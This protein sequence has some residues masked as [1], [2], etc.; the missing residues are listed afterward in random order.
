MIEES[1]VELYNRARTVRERAYVPYSE[2]AVGAALRTSDGR[3]FTGVNV[4]NASYGLSI[5]AERTAIFTAVSEVCRQFETLAIA[6]GSADAAP[7]CGACRQVM[8]EFTSELRIVYGENAED[9]SVR[10]LSELL[11]EPFGSGN[12]R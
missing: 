5:C 11:P 9:L 7:P 6:T 1:D 2:Y 12:L 8:G 10:T 4:E 3:V